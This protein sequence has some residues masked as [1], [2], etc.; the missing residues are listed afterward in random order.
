MDFCKTL[1]GKILSYSWKFSQVYLLWQQYVPD[2]N[3]VPYLLSLSCV[4]FNENYGRK[5][6]TG[7]FRSMQVSILESKVGNAL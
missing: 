4:T 1:Y 3:F 5:I 6:M 2:K 7:R